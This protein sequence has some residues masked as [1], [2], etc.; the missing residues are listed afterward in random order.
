MTLAPRAVLVHRRTE[1]RELLERHGTRGQADFYLR[2][3]NRRI[4]DLEARHEAAEAAIAAVSAA[5]PADWRRGL[6]ERDDLPRFLFAPDD[7]IVAVGQ[8]GLVANVAKYLDGQIVIGINPEPGRNPGVLVS[9]PAESA[10]ALLATAADAR[11]D[12]RVEHLTMVTAV[13]D[14][15]QQ[16]TALNEIYIGQATHQTARY[17]LSLPGGQTE[18]QASSGLIVSTGTG[19]TGW[20]R[21]A[22][23]ERKSAIALPSPADARLAWFVREAWPSPATSTTLTE[24]ELTRGQSL[25]VSVESDQL[26]VFGDGIEV[27][28]LPLTWGQTATIRIATKSLRRLCL[29]SVSAFWVTRERRNNRRSAALQPTDAVR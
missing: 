2:T 20:G 23:L 1:L 5:I 16:L 18:A 11:A 22:W 4:E 15:G 6:V 12:A 25:A 13:T 21:S 27:D 10:E 7:I 26:V 24:G 17:T 8:D 29:L 28:T 9:H 14:D 19:A 3:R